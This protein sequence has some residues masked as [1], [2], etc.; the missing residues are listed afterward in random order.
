MR[1]MLTLGF[2]AT[3]LVV[4][5]VACKEESQ[6]SQ[7]VAAAAQ[8]GGPVEAAAPA[9]GAKQYTIE[10]AALI[11][12]AGEK[13]KFSF[14]IKANTGL[15]FNKEFPAKFAMEATAFVKA[16]KEKLSMKDGDIRV[17]GNNGVVT[18]PMVALSA[19]K[20]EVKLK[21]NFSL[22]TDEQCYMLRDEVVTL[23]VTV[24]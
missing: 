19:G 8:P 24:K 3:S 6:A 21:G 7:P 13:S 9:A 12:K 23:Q 4:A 18:V 11:M 10:S 22:C 5:V 1:K 17:D 14:T 20:G 2:L 16:D 15:H